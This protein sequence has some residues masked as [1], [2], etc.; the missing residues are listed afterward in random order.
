M[1]C[2]LEPRSRVELIM[3]PALVALMLAALLASAPSAL[4]QQCTG[5]PGASAIQQYCEAIPDA[6]GDARRPSGSSSSGSS[7]SGQPSVPSSARSQLEQEG[8]DGQAIIGLTSGSGG[9]SEGASEGGSAGSSTS[10]GPS[11]TPSASAA[12]PVSSTTAAKVAEGG[13]LGAV[14]SSVSNGA[15]VG[16]GFAG[17]LV[18]MAILT[19][20]FGWILLRRR[21]DH[22]S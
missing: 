4:A 2:Q 16:D 13:V 17:I 15:T 8:D 21:H 14:S 3:R 9:P 22:T 11:S 1:T 19:G 5:R 12:E 10:G 7:G 20:A 18:A 6:S